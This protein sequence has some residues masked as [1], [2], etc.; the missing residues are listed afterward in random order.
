[1]N[2]T[3]WVAGATGLVGSHLMTLLCQHPAYSK[4]VAF[5]RAPSDAP[6]AEHEKVEQWQVDYDDLHARNP[7]DRVNDLF[8]ALGTTER[9]TPD[10]AAYY[11]VDV[12]YPLKF[13]RLGLDQ[14]GR[15]F[16]LVSAHGAN[17]DSLSGYLKMK[18][19]LEIALKALGYEHLVIARPSLLKGKRSEFRIAERMGELVADYFPGDL[20][21]IRA[22]DVASALIRACNSSA[23]GEPQVQVL[24]SSVMQGCDLSGDCCA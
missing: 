20:K 13:A 2:K 15:S 22:V 5:V 24:R 6:W 18:G 12:N 1:M 9:K 11:N 17:P 16:A 7:S 14:G 3:A 8:C 23:S 19:E 21:A 10:K 4:V